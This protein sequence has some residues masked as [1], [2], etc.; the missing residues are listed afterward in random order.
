MHEK[1][2]SALAMAKPLFWQT[3]RTASLSL[4]N[5]EEPPGDFVE[6]TRPSTLLEYRTSRLLV[7]TAVRSEPYRFTVNT[8]VSGNY[9]P[10]LILN[11]RVEDYPKPQC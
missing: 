7:R 9:I 5:V 6:L 1:A 8:I 3:L 11:V 2:R 4:A 10:R